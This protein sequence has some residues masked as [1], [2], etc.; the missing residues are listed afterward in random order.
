[1][2]TAVPMTQ[3][4]RS[5]V[6]HFKGKGGCVKNSPAEPWEYLTVS[7]SHT[8]TDICIFYLETK[9]NKTK[10]YCPQLEP[11]NDQ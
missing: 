9:N 3:T 6:F 1:M 4:G 8:H 11:Y 5:E 7:I 10:G 2:E